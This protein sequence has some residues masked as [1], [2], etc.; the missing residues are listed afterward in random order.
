MLKDHGLIHGVVSPLIR[1]WSY[2]QGGVTSGE[3]RYR[4]EDNITVLHSI[5]IIVD[6][7]AIKCILAD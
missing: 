7:N 6:K 1:P 2:L 4:Y 3:S 5:Y